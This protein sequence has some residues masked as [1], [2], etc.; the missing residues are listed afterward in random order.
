MDLPK[1]GGADVE[2]FFP[3]YIPLRV[4]GLS[5][6]SVLLLDRAEIS[7]AEAS[8]RTDV[9]PDSGMLIVPQSDGTPPKTHHSVLVPSDLYERIKDKPVQ[10]SAE[11]FLT[12]LQPNLS[13][14]MAAS[15]PRQLIHGV[16]QCATQL[17]A[18]ETAV[19][20]RCIEAGKGP[21]CATAFLEYVPSG[22]RNPERF[23][24]ERPDYSPFVAWHLYPD[25]L[26][27]FG[28]NLPFRDV[29]G[30]ARFPVDG[31]MLPESRVVL[32][33]FKIAA[34]VTENVVIPEIRLSDWESAQANR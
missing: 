5:A 29:T 8:G 1:G 26:T 27:R 31:S 28:V 14:E 12:L 10:F 25:A 22:A 17:N 2:R 19:Q 18:T 7:L 9:I 21:V 4:S 11:Y 3:V 33:T 16:G 23:S 32:R 30:L 6:S 24:C 13:A 34:H 20:L 15:S